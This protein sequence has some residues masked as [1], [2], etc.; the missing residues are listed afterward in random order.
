MCVCGGGEVVVCSISVSPFITGNFSLFWSF[1]SV[2]GGGVMCVC[3]SGWISVCVKGSVWESG[4]VEK[5]TGIVSTGQK[6]MPLFNFVPHSTPHTRTSKHTR[7][8]RATENASQRRSTS[9]HSTKKIALGEKSRGRRRLQP[10]KL[11]SVMKKTEM[12]NNM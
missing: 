4:E 1:T 10:E 5:E 9:V 2:C 8:M 3:I 12:F 6:I 11:V 7:K